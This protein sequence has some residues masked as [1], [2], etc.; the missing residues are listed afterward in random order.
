MKNQIKIAIGIV[1]GVHL[2]SNTLKSQNISTSNHEPLNSNISEFGYT[3]S[4]SGSSSG[5][6]AMYNPGV[7]ISKGNCTSVLAL[8]IQQRRMNFSGLQYTF[9][10]SIINLMKSVGGWYENEHVNSSYYYNNQDQSES[11]FDFFLFANVKYNFN[12]YL[13]MER[14]KIEK[15]I[16]PESDINLAK[17]K[18]SDV[19][20]CFGFGGKINVTEQLKIKGSIGVGGYNTLSGEKKLDRE[21]S[22]AGLFFKIGLIGNIR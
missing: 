19:E 20:G 15:Y 8:N 13:G 14:M 17:L 22:N 21:Y 16:Y 3:M 4:W 2:F 9:E 11:K 1:L 6:G 10:Y 12:A 7:F 5:F 18:F